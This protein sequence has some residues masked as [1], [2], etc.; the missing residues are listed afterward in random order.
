MIIEH[1]DTETQRDIL[2][3]VLSKKIK[4]CA[5]VPLCS[6]KKHTHYEFWNFK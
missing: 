3:F 6:K 5:F 1:R 4:L 2:F